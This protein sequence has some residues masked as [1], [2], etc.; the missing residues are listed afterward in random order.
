VVSI[1]LSLAM[2]ALIAY[3]LIRVLMR[4]FVVD[5]QLDLAPI[6]ETF[7]QDGLWSV[8]KNTFVAVGIS[9][10]LGLLL[11]STFAWLTERT[12][13]TLGR[14]TALLPIAPYLVPPIAGGIGWTLLLSEKAGYLNG[15]FRWL[16][17]LVGIH[18]ETG[19]LNIYSWWGLIALY[20]M[21][22]IPYAYLMVAA[23]LRNSD[24]TLEEQARVSGSGPAKTF[25]TVTLPALRPS[26]GAALMLMVW[27]GF[28]FYSVPAVIGTQSDIAVLPVRIVQLLNFTYPPKTG[29]AVGMSLFLVVTVG[30][31]WYAQARILR[32]NRHAAIGG[33]ARRHT[34]RP[35]GRWRLPAQLLLASYLLGVVVL[36]LAAFIM[37]SLSGFWTLHIQWDSLSLEPLRKSLLDDPVAMKA[38][39]TS[40]RLA[41]TGATIGILVAAVISLAVKRGVAGR[42]FIDGVV[43]IPAVFSPVVIALGF[44]LAFSGRP[45]MLN[46]TFWILLL[47]YIVLFIP[48]ATVSADAAA[49]QVGEELSEASRVSGAD[50]NKTFWRINLPLM[51]PGLLSG[52]A[53]LFVWMVGELN[54]SAILAGTRTPVIGFRIFD[55]FT[56]GNY[57]SLSALVLALTVLNTAVVAIAFWLGRWWSRGTNTPAA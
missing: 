11:G 12:D 50:Q 13:A 52:W 42:R 36:P 31:A 39:S 2:A 55:V 49:A 44:I 27:F 26:L 40:L 28:S 18:L 48:Q 1:G 32:S 10:V 57:A 14:V 47:C 21:Y 38:L 30:L 15:I 5:G 46:G 51:M 41:L 45:F 24:P 6:Q 9:S 35:L 7:Q 23:G 19:P 3:P 33:K 29:V 20:T 54:A 4:L 8:V 22:Q 43:K 34:R 53:L 16:L 37:V 25:L 56:Q 17:D